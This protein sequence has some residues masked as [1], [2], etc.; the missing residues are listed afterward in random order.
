VQ[1]ERDNEKHADLLLKQMGIDTTTTRRTADHHQYQHGMVGHEG[2]T[3]VVLD[4]RELISELLQF[5]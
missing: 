2:T 5:E 4:E 3:Y 1:I